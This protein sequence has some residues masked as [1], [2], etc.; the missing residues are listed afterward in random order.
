[1]VMPL[2][3]RVGDWR[4]RPGLVTPDDAVNNDECWQYLP[5]GVSP[6]QSA[7]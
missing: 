5:A 1:M 7:G 6:T 3:G 2:R 4:A